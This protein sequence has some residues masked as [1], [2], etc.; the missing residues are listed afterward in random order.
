VASVW[1]LTQTVWEKDF[2]WHNLSHS[3]GVTV[4]V[5]VELKQQTWKKNKV[6]VKGIKKDIYLWGVNS[7]VTKHSDYSI[8]KDMSE[9]V[10]R[11]CDDTADKIHKKRVNFC[12]L[13][14]LFGGSWVTK[15]IATKKTHKFFPDALPMLF[16]I[17]QRGCY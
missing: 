7:T 15:K 12:V 17:S 3:A 11:R 14:H 10:T 2:R 9:R 1:I 5:T 6:S 8:W 4:T 16:Q 13:K